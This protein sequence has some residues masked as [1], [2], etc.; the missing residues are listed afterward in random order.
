MTTTVALVSDLHANS[1]VAL[2][3]PVVNRDDGGTYRASAAQRWIWRQWLPYWEEVAK[4]RE[5]AGG[6]LVV[7]LNGE[8]ADD[9]YHGKF[10]LVDVNPKTQMATAIRALEPMLAILRPED[11]IYITRGTE[12]HSGRSAWM[13]DAI[14]ADLGAVSPSEGV[15]SYWHLRLNVEGV[16]FDVA[17]HPPL[18]PGRMPWTRQLYATRMASMAYFD[19]LQAGEKPPDLY[20]RGHY[21]VP[22]DSY[23]SYP[24]R[25]LALPSWQL[26]TAF[27]HRIG[28]GRPYPIGG[29][30]VTCDRGKYEV[31]KRYATWA[32]GGY[33]SVPT[34]RD[35]A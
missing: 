9:N 8:L 31:V 21:H 10:Q 23:D 13:D 25:A 11:H 20:V 15:H 12:A 30:I 28:G 1:T 35:E 5:K 2:C 26:T 33:E 3:P 27:G 17:H 6:P 16:R 24:V 14:G 18:G 22:S 4:R 29:A 7:I 32:A 19:A 34:G